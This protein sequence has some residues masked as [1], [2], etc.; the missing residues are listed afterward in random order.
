MRRQHARR[1]VRGTYGWKIYSAER[2]YDSPLFPA[3]SLT[4]GKHD[5][6]NVPRCAEGKLSFTV[7]N[8]CARAR[9]ALRVCVTTSECCTPRACSPSFKENHKTSAR[10]TLIEEK[11]GHV[12]ATGQFE[13][14]T[15][16][17]PTIV[18]G[19]DVQLDVDGG[20]TAAS[21][22]WRTGGYR[23]HTM[24]RARCNS[25]DCLLRSRRSARRLRRAPSCRVDHRARRHR[26]RPTRAPTPRRSAR[27][28]PRRRRPGSCVAFSKSANARGTGD[29]SRSKSARRARRSTCPSSPSARASARSRSPPPLGV[30]MHAA[31]GATGGA[32]DRG[33]WRSAPACCVP[34]RERRRSRRASAGGARRAAR[35]LRGRE[36]E[37][38]QL[39]LVLR[40]RTSGCSCGARARRR[41]SSR[42]RPAAAG[43]PRSR[44]RRRSRRARS[45]AAG[46]ARRRR[47]RRARARRRAPSAGAGRCT[48]RP[49][50]CRRRF[51]G[52]APAP[53]A[54]RRRFRTWARTRPP[55]RA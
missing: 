51:R 6:Q 13:F 2:F 55:R 49:R 30:R 9:G 8:R 36:V 29:G 18:S 52:A 33:A 10:Y 26:R 54:S 53:R 15:F 39:V 4:D 50:A 17:R 21:S 34:R 19:V 38:A 44:R 43:R 41:R 12:A 42:S 35:V 47:R 48:R 24:C 22:S 28:A 5:D 3:A 46:S 40:R 16:W 31:R 14:L 32:R 7:F 11:S 23:A 1:K 25:R 45:S 20:A 37:H 27:T